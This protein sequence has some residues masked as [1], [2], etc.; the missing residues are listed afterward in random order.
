MNGPFLNTPQ[1]YS[2]TRAA[3]DRLVQHMHRFLDNVPH[4]MVATV[5]DTS[6]H[7]TQ[8]Y[9]LATTQSGLIHVIGVPY[10]T[11]TKQMRI[12]VRRMMIGTNQNYVYD[13]QAPALSTTGSSG[14]L[15]LA[16]VSVTAPTS[17]LASV[18]SVP[19]DSGFATATGY[20]WHCFFYVP[21]KLTQTST[22]FQM[23]QTTSP[24]LSLTLELL[25]TGF[26]RFRSNDGHGYITT[27]TVS[28][29]NMHWV[30]IVPG[31]VGQ[32]LLVDTLSFYTGIQSSGD[33]PSFTGGGTSSSQYTLSVASNNDGSQPMPLGG[34]VSKIG[35]GLADTSTT[36]ALS[37]IIP[38]ADSDIAVG[39]GTHLLYLCNDT[40]E[41]ATAAN[42]APG[43]V[44]ALSVSAPLHVAALGPY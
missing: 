7:L 23:T 30:V 41:S 43:S 19:T 8:G 5:V 39:A 21:A 37:S 25:P 32:E 16:D 18:T 1:R 44:A 26:L 13:G 34:W 38:S 27:D 22:I 33:D 17:A 9:V 20:Y 15:F 24:N 2:K 6:F 14:S 11:V 12:L 31:Q 29:H 35:Y 28:A 4:T 36:A 42:T 3:S 40:P 10:G